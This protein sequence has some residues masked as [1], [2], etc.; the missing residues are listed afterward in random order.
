MGRNIAILTPFVL[1]GISNTATFIAFFCALVVIFFLL[2]LSLGITMNT[3]K[4]LNNEKTDSVKNNLIPNK[5][6][7]LNNNLINNTNK[8]NGSVN[9]NV[10]SGL[11]QNTNNINN[12]SNNGVSNVI[13]NGA[14]P[15]IHTSLNN[16]TNTGLNYNKNTNPNPNV[17]QRAADNFVQ[18]SK[19]KSHHSSSKNK[20]WPYSANQFVRKNRW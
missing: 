11:I 4:H 13:N 12:H 9:N 18:V 8:I 3:R 15:Q 1:T 6:T 5:N 2:G 19:T 10:S 20:N 7:N 17:Q 16:T 14:N